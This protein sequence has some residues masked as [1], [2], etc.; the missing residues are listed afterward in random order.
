MCGCLLLVTT[1]LF[2]AGAGALTAALGS[3]PFF[4]L[5]FVIPVRRV[6]R[7]DRE[8]AQADRAPRAPGS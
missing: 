7:L 8:Q 5:W 2:G 1:K 6:A 4:A 3:I